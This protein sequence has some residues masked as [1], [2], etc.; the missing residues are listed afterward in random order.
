MTA[1]LP[2]PAPHSCSSAFPRGAPRL[3]ALRA[4]PPPARCLC[5]PRRCWPLAVP[6]PWQ[7]CQPREEGGGARAE[8]ERRAEEAAAALGSPQA[9]APLS[10]CSVWARPGRHGP[11]APVQAGD[12]PRDR[13]RCGHPGPFCWVT[14]SHPRQR[15]S[16]GS[17][18]TALGPGPSGGAAAPRESPRTSRP[19]P[20]K[21]ARRLRRRP[22]STRL[23]RT[24][25]RQGGDAFLP[26]CSARGETRTCGLG[27]PALSSAARRVTPRRPLPRSEQEAARDRASL[28]PQRTSHQPS[29]GRPPAG[30]TCPQPGA[31]L[32]GPGTGTGT[33]RAL[34]PEPTPRGA[35]A[36]SWAVAASPRARVTLLGALAQNPNRARSSPAQPRRR[37]SPRTAAGAAA[38]GAGAHTPS[39]C[40]PGAGAHPGRVP[41]R[42]SGRVSSEQQPGAGPAP[43]LCIWG[44]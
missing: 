43:Q 26:T 25:A 42:P 18:G 2:T 30:G 12:G 27:A 33:G 29:S 35:S 6:V 8:A 22:Q 37:L 32:S 41:S 31:W 4:P 40:P 14:R 1:S 44:F 34:R 28:W 9:P 13:G 11:E 21:P 36:G 10:R 5:P 7:E 19:G 23:S 3:A 16:A 17:P 39:W 15:P 24:G 20:E 38:P